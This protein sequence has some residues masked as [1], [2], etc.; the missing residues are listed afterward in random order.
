MATN[1]SSSEVAEIKKAFSVFDVD[2]D[3]AI[4]SKELA[5][6]MRSFGLN[7]SEDELMDMINKFDIDGD[8]MVSFPEFLQMM[9]PNGDDHDKDVQEVVHM[10][11]SQGNGYMDLTEIENILLRFGDKGEGPPKGEELA[12]ITEMM[13]EF[14]KHS[15][16]SSE[17]NYFRTAD[18]IDLLTGQEVGTT[19]KLQ[20]QAMIE[21]AERE[22]AEALA[23]AEE[24]GSSGNLNKGKLE[25]K[26]SFALGGGK[27]KKGS[28]KQKGSQK[29]G[30]IDLKA[31]CN[32][33]LIKESSI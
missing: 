17:Y 30:Q 12:G 22:R 33:N 31:F 14:R 5:D 16:W 21:S 18:A 8:G 2:G 7:P 28:K 3:G 29:A 25:K 13:N 26:S 11:D 24:G 4:T 19:M 6:V 27:D 10:F 32:N 15:G 23:L 1:L 9:A 20:E